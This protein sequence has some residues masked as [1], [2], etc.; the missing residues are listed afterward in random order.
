[1]GKFKCSHAENLLKVCLLCLRKCKTMHKIT[2]GLSKRIA[3]KLS[4]QISILKD[5]RMPRAICNTCKKKCILQLIFS[6]YSRPL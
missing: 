4:E 1:M 5:N 2:E 6:R 3:E